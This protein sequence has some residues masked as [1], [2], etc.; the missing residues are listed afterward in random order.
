MSAAELATD[1]GVRILSNK[2]ALYEPLNY[3]YGAVWPFLTGYVA[4]AMYRHN[5]VLQAYLLVAANAEHF[6]DNSL[7]HSIELFSGAQHI[8]PQEAVAHQGFSL[9]GFVLP[10]VRGLLGLEIDAAAKE[11]FFKPSF[12]PDWREV[13]LENLRLGGE[14]F[15]SKFERGDDRVKLEI[16]GKSGLPYQMTFAPALERGTD[17][18]TVKVNGRSVNFNLE[19]SGQVTR[20][21]VRFELTG[22][23]AV[24][25]E[26]DPTVEVL[27]P[28]VK[29]RVGDPDKGLKIVRLGREGKNLDLKVE[30]LAGERYHLALTRSELVAGVTGAE[31]RDGGL[32]ILI[33]AGPSGRFLPCEIII[34]VR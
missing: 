34:Q 5:Q 24:E 6:F 11:V 22:Q 1:W 7:G 10:F 27:P 16:S 12:P 26:F 17:V 8:W 9:G 4:T 33:P 29:S 2:S 23:D 28:I 19:S 3:N 31:L 18:R 20:P 32:E 14:S 21:M 30:G 15:A 13:K 25:I